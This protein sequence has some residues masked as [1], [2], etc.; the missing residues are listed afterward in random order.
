MRRAGVV[1]R[2]GCAGIGWGVGNWGGKWNGRK[3]ILR[4]KIQ[5]HLH[6]K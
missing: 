2:D 5:S 4:Y 6:K 1:N 3:T